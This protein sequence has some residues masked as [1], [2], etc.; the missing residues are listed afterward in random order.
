MLGG[1]LQVSK[2]ERDAGAF[3]LPVHEIKQCGDSNGVKGHGVVP[4]GGQHGLGV[5]RGD[6]ARR[7]RLL[8]RTLVRASPDSF[9]PIGAVARRQFVERKQQLAFVG[10]RTEQVLQ[11][12]GDP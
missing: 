10:E 7:T 12:G 11:T 1:A 9:A 8:P 5:C 4:A 3:R 2:V 6:A